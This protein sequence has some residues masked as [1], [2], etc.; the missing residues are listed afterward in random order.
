MA[1]SVTTLLAGGKATL[2]KLG[3]EALD[4]VYPPR[5]LACMEFTD[6]PHGLCSDCWRETFFIAGS[7]C[8]SC[9]VP[10]LGEVGEGDVC[11]SCMR[12]PPPWSRG[13]AA[14]VYRGAARRM[15]L[16]LKH[17]DRLDMV[18][19]LAKWMSN[20]GRDVIAE[21]DIIAPVPLHWRRLLK[22]RY[23]QAG[24]LARGVARLTDTPAVYDLL[25]RQ[26]ATVA[27]KQ[28]NREERAANQ[29]G[30]IVVHPRHRE[31]VS[32]K[33]VLL[34]DDVLT[35]GATLGTCTEALLDAGALRVHV[36]ALCRVAFHEAG[37]I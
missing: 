13:A 24:E 31:R 20:A 9:G 17:A 37:P 32:G 25:Q 21:A 3:R 4:T 36:L 27:Q 28:M 26:R 2:L 15:V 10:L 34:V 19:P 6:A 7:T 12:H 14:L 33:T 5:C 22:R 11:E 29:A 23:N 30:A 1:A 8:Q 18:K 16:G 35:S